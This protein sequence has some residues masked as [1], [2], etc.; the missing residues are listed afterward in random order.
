M[1]QTSGA[2]SR[3]GVALTNLDGVR[4]R[5]LPVLEDRPLSVIRVHRGQEAFMHKNV[6][7]Y[8]PP[9]VRTVRMWAESSNRDVSY[10]LCNDRRTLLFEGEAGRLQRKLVRRRTGVFSAGA[11]RR[12]QAQAEDLVARLE[13]S[14]AAA[15]GRYIPTDVVAGHAVPRTTQA[16]HD[17]KRQGRAP[18]PNTSPM[19]RL[20]AMTRTST[21]SSPTSGSARSLIA[22]TSGP[23]YLS[24]TTAFN[25]LLL[26]DG[27]A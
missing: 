17:P 12:P 3:E 22:R 19:C 27:G 16:T 8:M 11:C 10:A 15:D 5:I 1:N 25:A 23:P 7:K 26:S 6:P 20:A 4:D 2:E 14:D 13:P 21:S 24:W 18:V 9:W